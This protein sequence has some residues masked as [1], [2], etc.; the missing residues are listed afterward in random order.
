[1]KQFIAARPK[2]PELCSGVE[3]RKTL[4]EKIPRSLL[5]GYFIVP[6]TLITV[7]L[8]SCGM[9]KQILINDL[10]NQKARMEA[11]GNPAMKY[12]INQELLKTRIELKDLL[13]KDVILSSNIDYNFCVIADVQTDRGAVECYIYST[14]IKTIAGLVIGESRIDVSGDFGRFFTML[15]DYYTMLDII[16]ASIRIRR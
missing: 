10:V 12:E 15:K 3:A 1:M 5:R 7:L 9:K 2:T 11:T 4:C 16:N 13:V 14:D 6:C 8:A